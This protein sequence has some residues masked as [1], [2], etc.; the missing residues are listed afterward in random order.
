VYSTLETQSISSTD[1]RV[2]Y[3]TPTR[4]EAPNWLAHGKS[5]IFNSGGRIRRIP[6]AGGKPERIDT[7]FATRCNNDHGVSPDRT[8]LVIS[9]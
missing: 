6:A 1:R 4:I 9:D 3:V 2:A 8:R 5:L 7:G